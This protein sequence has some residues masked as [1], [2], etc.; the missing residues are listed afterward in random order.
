MTVCRTWMK[1]TVNLRILS[2]YNVLISNKKQLYQRL[3]YLVVN[4]YTYPHDYRSLGI[5]IV[6]VMNPSVIRVF[7]PRAGASL[8]VQEPRLQ[9]CQRQVFHRKLRKQGCTFTRD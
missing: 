4:L 3:E 1:M 5:V 8:Q 2:A 9:F 6:H 7:C